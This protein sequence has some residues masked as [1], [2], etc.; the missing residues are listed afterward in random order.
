MLL[1]SPISYIVFSFSHHDLPLHQHKNS[2]PSEHDLP[3]QLELLTHPISNN[4]LSDVPSTTNTHSMVTRFK[5]GI[6]KPKAVFSTQTI[7]EA[8]KDKWWYASMKCE[9]YALVKK[10]TWILVPLR[11]VI[12]NK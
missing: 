9:F 8:I 12:N 3:I 5:V 11:K 7:K 1:S 10:S 6:K 4:A 2:L